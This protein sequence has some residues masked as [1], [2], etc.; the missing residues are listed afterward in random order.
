M[1]I[2]SYYEETLCIFV[3]GWVL[4]EMGSWDSLFKH[5]FNWYF[6]GTRMNVEPVFHIQ[7]S[8]KEMFWVL[9]KCVG[10]K[11]NFLGLLKVVTTRG[12]FFTRQRRSDN[13][14]VQPGTKVILSLNAFT[15]SRFCQT[16]WHL[17]FIIHSQQYC[18]ISI[19]WGWTTHL[20][21]TFYAHTAFTFAPHTFTST[22]E[23]S[24]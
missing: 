11:N 8:F 15:P 5:N 2:D 16:Q 1:D 23:R 22:S 17:P 4:S 10:K 20:Q 13:G 12:A 7:S 24:D 3:V 19:H 21:C 18:W 14:F 9:E 6:S